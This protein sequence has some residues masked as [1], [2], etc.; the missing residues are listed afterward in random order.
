MRTVDKLHRKA[1]RQ[2][3]KWEDQKFKAEQ[4]KI[5]AIYD[6]MSVPELR[7]LALGFEDGTLTRER[8][9]E[10]WVAAG[11]TAILAGEW[12]CFNE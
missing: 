9:N 11:G 4:E 6:K 8:F 5:Q 1:K 2:L 7:E 10:I 12:E 3:P